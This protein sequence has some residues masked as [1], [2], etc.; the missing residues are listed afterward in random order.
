MTASINVCSWHS[1]ITRKPIEALGQVSVYAFA[2]T[3][4]FMAL[5]NQLALELCVITCLFSKSARRI[6]I[7]DPV[8]KLSLLFALFFLVE[9]V[10]G[11]KLFPE[12]AERQWFDY[13]R[14]MLFLSF[15]FV[16]WW[17]KAELRRINLILLLALTGQLLGILRFAK[18]DDVIHF[19][20]D[21]QT[22]FQMT[23]AS[24]GLISANAILGM[25]IFMPR[26]IAGIRHSQYMGFQLTAWLVAGYLSLFALISSQSRGTWLGF[27]ILL[28]IVL[29]L[30]YLCPSR[31]ICISKRRVLVFTWLFFALLSAAVSHN[32]DA[33][34]RRTAHD[35]EVVSLVL[36]GQTSELPDSSFSSRYHVQIF[37]IEKW[38]ERPLM[39]WGTASS[40]ILL[41]GSGRFELYNNQFDQWMAHMHN[42]YLEILVRFGA[43][44]AIFFIVLIGL[45]LR[46]VIKARQEGQLPF[47]YY[48]FILGSLALTAI[49]GLSSH[50]FEEGWRNYWLILMGIAYTFIYPIAEPPDFNKC[51][52][53][54]TEFTG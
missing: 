11:I 39:G 51:G 14:M 23:P 8:I 54:I 33:L 41:S 12:S 47:D 46:P 32:W 52:S 31:S 3:A 4:W 40:R 43:V 34:S 18:S 29:G 30:R 7:K 38:L 9:T 37:G 35:A 10:R 26:I 24:S 22:G 48:L 27:L 49:W 25:I 1:H 15:P 21:W 36:Q 19:H 17:L 6:F 44:G 28:P 42:A 2:F 5:S 53:K 20:T 50:F 13:G 16:G 45:A